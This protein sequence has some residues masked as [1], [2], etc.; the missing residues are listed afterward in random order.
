M[1]EKK[2]IEL[3]VKTDLPNMTQQLRQA[4]R[5]VTALS[6][7]FGATSQEAIN[8]ARRAAELKD[9]IGDAK[10]LTDAYNPDAKFKALSSSISGVL[11]GFQAY[12][13][14]LGIIG[15][16][17]KAVE[18]TLLKVQSAM[19]LAQGIDGVLESVDA[20]KTLY[21]QVTNNVAVQKIFNFV[22]KMNPLGLIVTGIAAVTAGY[23]AY[24]QMIEKTTDSLEENRKKEEEIR[25]ARNRDLK[26]RNEQI[27]EAK[28]YS[29]S[30]IN[31]LENELAIMKSKG[32]TDRQIFE[33]EKKIIQERLRISEIAKFTRGKYTFEE[34]QERKKLLTDLE[35]LENE[36]RNKKKE[37]VTKEKK[38]LKKIEE[39]FYDDLIDTVKLDEEAYAEAVAEARKLNAESVLSEQEIELKAI[40]EKYAKIEESGEL[41][42]ELIIAQKN[43]LNDINVKYAQKEIDDNKAKNDKILADDKILAQQKKDL[44]WENVNNVLAIL[45]F[46]GQRNRKAAK[47][48][49]ELNKGISIAQ[50]VIKTFEAAQ[51]AFTVGSKINPVYA[52]ISAGLAVAAGL[53]NVSKIAA[54]KFPEDGGGSSVP[55][56]GNSFSNAG[57]SSAGLSQQTAPS[58][59]LVGQSGG[60]QFL[61]QQPIQAYVVSGEV[62]S[63]QSLDRNRLFNATFG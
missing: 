41:T 58:F 11:N 1:A 52:A 25:Q 55:S 54:Q 45:E 61:Q 51:N 42:E 8:A 18:E 12:E 32:A 57:S 17:S 62:T 38:E 15:V 2:V 48:A 43:E 31:N 37:A 34:F 63:Q 10:A 14:A 4:Q 26:D 53:A 36:F 13:G 9:A 50:T 39:D 3:E 5:E 28:E 24:Q 30:N 16:E 60:G 19:A 59:N 40:N 27:K 22:M 46:F 33:Q 47:A 21:K 49:F 35:V 20:F 6:E 7:K 23:F 56:G 44:A 29:Q